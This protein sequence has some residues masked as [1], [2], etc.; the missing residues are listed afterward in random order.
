[1][2]FHSLEDR[3]VKRFTHSRCGKLGEQSRHTPNQRVDADAPR[4][5]LPKPEKRQ[6]SDAEIAKNPRSRSATLR[7]MTRH[8]VD[9]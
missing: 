4:F 2:T 9:V 8:K 3:I 5:F 7:M 6:A 1:M